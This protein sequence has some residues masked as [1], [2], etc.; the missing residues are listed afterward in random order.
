MNLGMEMEFVLV[1]EKH[2]EKITYYTAE[3]QDYDYR[4]DEDDG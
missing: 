3:D 4:E 2:E 1:K